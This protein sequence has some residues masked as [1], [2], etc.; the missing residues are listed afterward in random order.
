MPLFDFKCKQGHQTEVR[1][2]YDPLGEIPCP[3]CGRP[4]LRVRFYSVHIRGDTVSKALP[5]EPLEEKRERQKRQLKIA[6][7]DGDRAMEFVRKGVFEDKKGWKH[8][9]Q[10]LAYKKGG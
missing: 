10:S 1:A 2:G 4:A 5:G 3:T 8:F 9:S 6:G 7:W